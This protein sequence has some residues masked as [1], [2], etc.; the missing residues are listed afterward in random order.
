MDESIESGPLSDLQSEEDEGRR[1]VDRRLQLMAPPVDMRGGASLV[2][3]L[4]E[5]IQSQDND[6]AIWKKIEVWTAVLSLCLCPR[7]YMSAGG[8][9]VLLSRRNLFSLLTLVVFISSEEPFLY[10]KQQAL[11]TT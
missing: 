1:S 3:Q 5:D 7:F 6:P 4:L 8:F 11:Q 10:C 9:G 2:H